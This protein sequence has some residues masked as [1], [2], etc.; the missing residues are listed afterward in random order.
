MNQTLFGSTVLGSVVD[1]SA[2]ESGLA[3]RWN[4]VLRRLIASPRMHARWLN[5]LS[6]LEYMGC[7]KML[8]ALPAAT[9]DLE[10]LR[11]IREEARHASLFKQWSIKVDADACPT[12]DEAYLLCGTAA[13]RYF[14]Q[15][16]AAVAAHVVE[17]SEGVQHPLV[18]YLCMTTLV[19]VRATQVYGLHE[20]QLSA[21]SLGFSLAAVLN[22]EQRH[23]QAMYGALATMGFDWQRHAA[24]LQA[25]EQHLVSA[26]LDEVENYL[27]GLASVD[28]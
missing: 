24:A 8:K 20:A 3:C 7:R 11:H 26:W 22:D 23:L 6:L 21:A 17:C 27:D 12:Y 28:N 1:H 10:L 16:D 18:P 9:I 15:L 5:T 2:L 4:E 25:I 19:E 14:Q 13:R